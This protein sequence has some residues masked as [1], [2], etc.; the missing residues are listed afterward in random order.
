MIPLPKLPATWSGCTMPA[1]MALAIQFIASMMPSDSY[2]VMR[3]PLSS[4]IQ[5]A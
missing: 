1:L 2:I 5:D 3:L 4:S